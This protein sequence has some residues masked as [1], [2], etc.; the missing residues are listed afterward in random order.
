MR[1]FALSPSPGLSTFIMNLRR[2]TVSEG[3]LLSGIKLGCSL[4]SLFQG[5]YHIDILLL[6]I[7]L[8][9]N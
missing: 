5:E 4:F 1:Q 2:H 7:H 3:K 6:S 9:Y 8:I